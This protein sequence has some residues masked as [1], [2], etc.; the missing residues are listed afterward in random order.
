[1]SAGAACSDRAPSRGVASEVL[2][3]REKEMDLF[4]STVLSGDP[5]S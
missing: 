4:F 5:R 2:S 3:L 1:M